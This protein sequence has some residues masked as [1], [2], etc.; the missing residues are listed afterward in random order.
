MIQECDTSI[1]GHPFIRQKFNTIGKGIQNQVVNVYELRLT[2]PVIIGVKEILVRRNELCKKVWNEF[3][4]TTTLICEKT[5]PEY[6]HSNPKFLHI[7]H[8]KKVLLGNYANKSKQVGRL[9]IDPCIKRNI[10][11]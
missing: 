1:R 2:M 11:K 9:N 10:M 3:R 6:C 7:L 8:H 4:R 5:E